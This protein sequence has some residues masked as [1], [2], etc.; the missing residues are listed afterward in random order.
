MC[1]NMSDF[2]KDP[3]CFVILCVSGVSG[4]FRCFVVVGRYAYGHFSIFKKYKPLF[5]G[6]L[7][8][9]L[10]DLMEVKFTNYAYGY[11]TTKLPSLYETVKRV[12]DWDTVTAMQ[13]YVSPSRGYNLPTLD[14]ED[15]ARAYRL[16]EQS[17][18]WLC[19]H[20][21][22]VHNPAGSKDLKN[23]NAEVMLQNTRAGLT[24]EMDIIA[25]MGGHGVV[26]HTGC[27]E[28]RE[29]GID[30]IANTIISSL[31]KITSTTEKL[32]HALSISPETL[33]QRRKIILENSAGEGSKIGGTLQDFVDIFSNL[34]SKRPELL[35]QVGICMDT[36]HAFGAGLYDW[37]IP[38]E[39][40]RFYEEF[41]TVIGLHHLTLFHLNDSRKS[42]SKSNNAPFG[43]KKDRHAN[44]GMGYVFEG[45]ERECG[46]KKFF[47]LAYKHHIPMIGEPPTKTNDED[48]AGPGGKR[49]FFFV[50]DVLDKDPSSKPLFTIK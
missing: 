36:A 45:E 22:L 25:S 32:A 27:C 3:M 20:S 29:V 47:E 15:I 26:V 37:G 39:V 10:I 34:K 2:F 50:K 28:D 12:V 31:D 11:H 42:D 44:I 19:A 38:E 14:T 17:G 21:K 4:G 35:S 33:V 43:S 5:L 7:T 16:V 9:H 18:M 24:Y 13:I 48:E 6:Y 23:P 49:D 8:E 41:D 40:E 30:L 46:L 1:G